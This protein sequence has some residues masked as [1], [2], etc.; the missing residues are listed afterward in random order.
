MRNVVG[1]AQRSFTT[2]AIQDVG[3]GIAEG[4]KIVEQRRW[5]SPAGQK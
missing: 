5:Y 4:E 2:N 3:R 1:L